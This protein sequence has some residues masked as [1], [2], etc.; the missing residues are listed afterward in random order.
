MDQP[1]RLSYLDIL[2]GFA[3]ILVVGLHCYAYAFID[4]KNGLGSFENFWMILSGA[5]VPI[6]FFVDGFLTARSQSRSV[7]PRFDEVVRKSARRLLVPWLIF[8]FIYV[9]LRALFEARGMFPTRL[10]VGQP[11]G[12]VLANIIGSR[13]AMQLYF[14]PALFVIRIAA[15]PLRHVARKPILAFVA[16]W[17][18][19]I[20]MIR[21]AGVT[22]EGDPLSQAFF[23]FQYFL[24]GMLIYQIELIDSRRWLGLLGLLALVAIAQAFFDLNANIEG[25]TY[26][27]VKYGIIAA[28]YLA[29][30]WAIWDNSPLLWIGHR[31]MQIYLLHAP[32]LLKV[33]QIIVAKVTREA[34]L[35][36]A[37]I[38]ALTV[39][40][41]VIITVL[42]ARFPQSKRI[43]GEA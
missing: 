6:F 42:L 28:T 22:L 8:N 35:R 3:I 40:L 1:N 37:L 10:V 16:I 5:A 23:G 38:W 4:Q 18:G 29:S 7:A 13:I 27:I 34:L 2:R 24:F 31:S 20:A 19:Y 26:D 9:G 17:L 14:L 12:V 32:V 41:S 33:V 30:K 21:M 25:F 43:F 36:F 15:V 39:L 11:I